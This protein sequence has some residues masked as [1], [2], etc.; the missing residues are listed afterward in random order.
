MPTPLRPLSPAGVQQIFAQGAEATVRA[1]VA[2]EF[3]RVVAL[4]ERLLREAE[5]TPD[6][7][8]AFRRAVGAARLSAAVVRDLPGPRDLSGPCDLS[9]P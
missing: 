2:A 6:Q 1:D 5:A 9:A 3:A 4:L 7:V 8:S